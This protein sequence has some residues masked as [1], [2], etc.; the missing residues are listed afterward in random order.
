M[1]IHEAKTLPEM[2]VALAA[3]T[4]CK[5]W[6]DYSD[7]YIERITGYTV[8]HIEGKCS[9]EMLEEMGRYGGRCGSM[10]FRF[11]IH[12]FRPN[13]SEYYLVS[14]RNPENDELLNFSRKLSG[15]SDQERIRLLKN[16]CEIQDID[17]EWK[18]DPAYGNM[19][20]RCTPKVHNLTFRDYQLRM[21]ISKLFAKIVEL[22]RMFG[23]SLRTFA[24]PFNSDCPYLRALSPEDAIKEKAVEKLRKG[25]G[26]S[27]KEEHQA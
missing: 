20:Y 18:L 19:Y 24:P 1:S 4:G 14:L 12:L 16:F 11:C 2:E 23:C 9:D 17:C 7:K 13:D 3:L 5:C 10:E 6:V 22:F 27:E 21:K 26:E 25:A 8:F 15:T